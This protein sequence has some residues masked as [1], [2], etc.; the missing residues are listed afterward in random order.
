MTASAICYVE[1]VKDGVA[2][3]RVAVTTNGRDRR[4]VGPQFNHPRKAARYADLIDMKI[5]EGKAV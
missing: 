5:A 3:Y 4:T 1:S 2:V